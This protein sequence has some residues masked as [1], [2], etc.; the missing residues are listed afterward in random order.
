MNQRRA[1]AKRRIKLTRKHLSL[2]SQTAN[3]VFIYGR[4]LNVSKPGVG[5]P[6]EVGP[7]PQHSDR[8]HWSSRSAED[9]GRGRQTDFS[10]PSLRR[11][12]TS[13]E[14]SPERHGQRPTERP[15]HARSRRRGHF[16]ES[17]SRGGL[18]GRPAA[19]FFALPETHGK[20]QSTGRHDRPRDGPLRSR[21]DMGKS[22]RRVRALCAMF[23]FRSLLAA[24]HTERTSQTLIRGEHDVI[25]PCDA[26]RVN[27]ASVRLP[28]RGRAWKQTAGHAI[29]RAFAAT[30]T[31]RIGAEWRI[32][33]TPNIRARMRLA[34]SLCVCGRVQQ[35][36]KPNFKGRRVGTA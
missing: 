26:N 24:F 32:T 28:L 12:A 17:G 5:D 15:P 6:L 30:I 35:R 18:N 21:F 27:A 36:Q 25:L 33:V 34:G 13:L 3:L 22:R 23:G 1:R 20:A 2:Q 14:V 9:R 8:E 7:S 4:R 31:I 11:E 16:W 10:S 29:N 19:A